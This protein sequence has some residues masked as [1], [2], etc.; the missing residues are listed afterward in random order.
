M[1]GRPVWRP[2]NG[3]I[4]AEMTTSQVT[5][6]VFSLA[7]ADCGRAAGG[8]RRCGSP[9]ATR[10][11]MM[12]TTTP[13]DEDEKRAAT[14]WGSK[15]GFFCLYVCVRV[16]SCGGELQ[17]ARD[18]L[19]SSSAISPLSSAAFAFAL[20]SRLRPRRSHTDNKGERAHQRSIKPRAARSHFGAARLGA[21]PAGAAE[22]RRPDWP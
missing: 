22:L 11:T 12:R 14:R 6:Q 19:L 7:L 4:A 18:Q 2:L 16:T 8:R 21:L 20:V 13:R 10:L 1:C 5:N 17:C 9:R 15:V 3:L